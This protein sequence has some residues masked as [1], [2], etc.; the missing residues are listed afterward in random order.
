MLKTFKKNINSII[1]V[2]VTGLLAVLIGLLLFFFFSY[3]KALV[4]S[5]KDELFDHYY[6]M[7]TESGSTSMWQSVYES[8]FAAGKEQNAYV[9]LM[10]G[11]LS[12]E[13]SPTEMM[14]IAIAS[15]V[16]GIIV[17][18]NESEE[19]TALINKAYKEEIPVVT[20]Y[21]DNTQSERLSFVGIGNYNLGKEYGN[22]LIKMA[23]TKIFSGST[24]KVSVLI[25]ANAEDSGQN[26]LAAAIQETIDRDNEE[27]KDSHKPIEVSMFAVDPTNNF[28]IEES[29]RNLFITS[30]SKLPN[31]VVCLSE[32]DTTSMYQAVVDYN[33][34]GLVNILGYYDSDAIIKGI[35]RNVIYAT[36]S[37]DTAQMGR[38]CIDALTEYYELGNTS[39]YY[40]ADI[41]VIDKDNVATYR[42]EALSED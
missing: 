1:I 32:T 39:Q 12:R 5:E 26:V 6:V 22:L 23:N 13:Y 8:A 19:M 17:A 21:T 4:K 11:N 27:N 18:A 38:Y 20:L 10:S 14:E 31:I 7:I 40:P 28:S 36:V 16:D 15:G 29:V 41:L 25:D 24:I 9:E 3:S 37:I 30:R 33:E 42:E 35:E 34:V 2:S